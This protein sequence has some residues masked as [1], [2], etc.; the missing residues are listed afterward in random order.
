MANYVLIYTGGRMP[1]S[2]TERKRIDDEWTNWFK[3]L[4]KAVIDQGNPFS[5]MAKTILEDGKIIEDHD[6]EMLT[7]YTVI[8][9][10]SMDAAIQMA[11]SCPALRSGSKI[12]VY[13]TMN[14]MA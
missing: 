9:A 12:A 4:D 3:R 6:C 5:P 10:M 11:K 7:G 1:A 2:E 13:E 8:Q 14:V